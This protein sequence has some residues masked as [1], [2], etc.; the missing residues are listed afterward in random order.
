MSH[1]VLACILT[2]LIETPFLALWGGYR[3]REDL[4][5]IACANA[6][7]NLLLNLSFLLFLPWTPLGIAAGEL[8]V[9]A[10]ECAIYA[11]AFGPSARL[12]FLT[13]LANALSLSLGLLIRL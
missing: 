10:L 6:F 4:A 5:I 9:L 13:L 8:A 7:T 1:I 3:G 11:R 2:V 12:F